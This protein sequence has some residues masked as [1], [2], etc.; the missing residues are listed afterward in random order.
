MDT[1]SRFLTKEYID[2]KAPSI[3]RGKVDEVRSEKYI[4]TPTSEI[5]GAFGKVNWYPTHISTVHPS[6][7][8]IHSVK[9]LIR[10]AS[11]E[12]NTKLNGLS[13]EVIVINS[14]NG[15]S[16]LTTHL[17]FFRFACANGIMVGTS[18][19]KL[20]WSHRK[21]DYSEVK[22]L[23]IAAT[24]EFSKQ[25]KFI[26]EYMKIKLGTKQQVDFAEKTINMVWNGFMFEPERL[27]EVKRL[28]DSDNTLWNTFNRIQEHIIKGGIQYK[29]PEDRKT[30]NEFR[31]THRI[32]N[33][34][35]EVKINLMLWTMMHNFY[36]NGKF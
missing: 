2:E 36:E 30:R 28:D 3:Y 17:G 12:I 15:S 20:K 7:R 23:I 33:I 11:E 31:T 14:H 19:S 24:D 35:K 21:M 9:H 32:K 10:F 16:P 1:E 27:L 26:P 13:P 5:V 34:D 22:N 6:K 8:D 25:N 29:V 18:I 4:F